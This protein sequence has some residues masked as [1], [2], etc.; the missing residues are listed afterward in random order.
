VLSASIGARVSASIVVLG[1][2]PAGATAARL[3]ALWGHD[4]RLITRPEPPAVG[5][6]AESLPPSCRKLFDLLGVRGAI[7][8]AGFVR[9][10]GNTVWWGAREE[11]VEHFAEGE[12]GWQVDSA[13]LAS[14]LLDAAERT[15]VDIERRR[16]GPDD[17][18]ARDDSIVL[19]C[20]GRSGVVARARGW[21]E[22]EPSLKTIALVGS[23]RRSGAWPV[24]DDT[25]TLIESY[26]DGWL[27]S[28]PL[29]GS[30]RCI[31]AM[32]DPRT[33]D[34]AEGAVRAIYLAEIAKARRFAS[35]VAGAEL[36]PGLRGWDAS[37]YSASRYADENVLLVGDAASFIDPLSSAGVKKAMASGWLAA[38]AAHTAIQRPGMRQI[39]FDFFTARE[40]DIYRRLRALTR[41]FLADA[42][43]THPDA[44]WA[45]RSATIDPPSSADEAEHPRIVHEFER[46][47]AARALSVRVGDGIRIES[48]PAVSGCEIVLESRIVDDAA[49]AGVRYVRDIDV[50]A[51][52]DLAPHYGDVGELFDA[53]Q[54]RAAPAA[55]PDFL[56]ALSAALAHGWLVWREG[57][58]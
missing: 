53:Y 19:D 4:V 20:T 45:D 40:R 16:V 32:V 14:L 1:G 42:A 15:G 46:L 3:L 28:V 9:A 57:S 55:L 13:V 8:T 51:L 27:W 38:V 48:R 6:L 10:T 44:F 18:A 24:P 17:C 47:R 49:S 36:E 34:L 58:A 50:V 23:W 25:H 39:A 35:I 41:R 52:L 33:S 22:Y 30:R 26:G 2:G 31:A 29:A 54:R 56:A 37:M 43:T 5:A 21:R 7:D 11:R 12:R